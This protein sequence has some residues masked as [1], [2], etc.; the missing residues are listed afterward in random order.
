MQPAVMAK[1]QET[2]HNVLTMLMRILRVTV[3]AVDISAAK[4]R[5]ASAVLTMPVLMVRTIIIILNM[6]R[7]IVPQARVVTVLV[8][9]K[10]VQAVKVMLKAPAVK[11][12]TIAEVTDSVPAVPV[13]TPMQSIATRN[14]WSTRRKIMI[15]MSPSV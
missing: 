5:G 6:L 10:V 8:I 11:V 13:T 14:A 1:I 15:P 2:I 3:R 12:D 4:I 7:V 9:I